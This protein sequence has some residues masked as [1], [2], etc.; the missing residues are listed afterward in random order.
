MIMSPSTSHVDMTHSLLILKDSSS[1]STRARIAWS[2]E[3]HRRSAARRRAGGGRQ[4]SAPGASPEEVMAQEAAEHWPAVRAG[5]QQGW[6]QG[7]LKA[8]ENI[9]CNWNPEWQLVPTASSLLLGPLQLEA[10]G[11]K[12]QP[13]KSPNRALAGA[14]QLPACLKSNSWAGGENHPANTST[15]LLPLEAPTFPDCQLNSAQA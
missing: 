5:T 11:N 6:A 1:S 14:E 13:G 9:R 15:P 10:D 3:P 7:L 4:H 2:P 8:G 12:N